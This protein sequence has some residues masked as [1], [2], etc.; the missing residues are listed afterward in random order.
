MWNSVNE[1]PER[2]FL[3][4]DA[5]S[6]LCR[7]PRWS[8]E[9]LYLYAIVETVCIHPDMTSI[10]IVSNQDFDEEHLAG[11]SLNDC[12]TIHLCSYYPYIANGY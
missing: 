7:Q 9:G 3:I 12:V 6:P 4:H 11:S 2:H 5:M 10:N 8:T 1:K